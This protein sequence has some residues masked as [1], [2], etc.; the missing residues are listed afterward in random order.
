MNAA[1]DEMFRRGRLDHMALAVEDEDTLLEI[2]ERLVSV[3]AADI[4]FSGLWQSAQR[5][6]H[7]SGW[8]GARGVL[9][10]TRRDLGRR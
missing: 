10:E 5:L 2:R 3:G 8:D 6:V 7:G 1:R 4:S 9:L